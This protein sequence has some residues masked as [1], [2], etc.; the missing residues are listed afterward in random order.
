MF[1]RA[2]AAFAVSQQEVSALRFAV[3]WG[4][5]TTQRYRRVGLVSTSFLLFWEQGVHGLGPSHEHA[6]GLAVQ[7]VALISCVP[8]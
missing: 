8:A 1:C 3:I 5:G 6:W 2:D 7:S 4:I